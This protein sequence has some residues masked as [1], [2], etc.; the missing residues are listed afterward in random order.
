[1]PPARAFAHD[2][3]RPA[4]PPARHVSRVWRGTAGDRAPLRGSTRRGYRFR[5]LGDLT[6][7]E[8]RRAGASEQLIGVAKQEAS[9]DAELSGLQTRV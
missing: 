1:M 3:E 2:P 5:P 9:V 4:T 7:A 6:A 8:T